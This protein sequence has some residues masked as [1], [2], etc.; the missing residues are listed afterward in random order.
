[1]R[2]LRAFV[3]F[4]ACAGL[5]ACSPTLD[6]REL[7]PEGSGIVATF[8]C[9]P[10]HHTRELRVGDQA[11][12]MHMVV[13]SAGGTTF[14]VSFAEVA[15]PAAVTSV[16]ASLRAA[17]LAN[18]AGTLRREREW[19]LAGMTPGP[20]AG[21]LEIDGRLPD[22]APVQVQ[23]AFFARGLRLYQASLLGPHPPAEAVQGFF[24]GLRLNSQ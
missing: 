1:M 22:G 12:R 8:P 14:A 13:C 5:A 20:A 6:W 2:S 21:L 7:Q 10:D 3:V 11:L 4:A 23:A 16:L 24:G 19:R 9:K 18:V 17:A 15:D